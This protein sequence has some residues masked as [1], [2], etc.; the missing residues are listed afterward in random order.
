MGH[1]IW[2]WVNKILILG[3]VAKFDLGPCLKEFYPCWFDH[4]D[5][6]TLLGP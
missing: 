2:A 6:G 4:W 5:S 1:L 3:E